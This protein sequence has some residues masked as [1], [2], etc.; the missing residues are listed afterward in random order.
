M[1]EFFGI[2]AVI[3]VA[4]ALGV[5]AFAFAQSA[6]R[7]VAALAWPSAP[8]GFTVER[9]FLNPDD[10]AWMSERAQL[11]HLGPCGTYDRVVL[12]YVG[13]PAH[14]PIQLGQP[15]HDLRRTLGEDVSLHDASEHGFLWVSASTRTV[16]DVDFYFGMVNQQE[17]M[18]R[19]EFT[20]CHAKP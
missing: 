15:L 1:V 7:P 4:L 20:M 12:R 13:D 18:V 3:V 6:A 19:Y 9:L 14:V 16:A 11:A 2:K 5:L 8:A 17:L 10:E